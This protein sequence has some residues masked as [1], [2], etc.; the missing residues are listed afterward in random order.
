MKL[1][2]KTFYTP[3]KYYK[4]TLSH[5]LENIKYNEMKKYNMLLL[6]VF[7]GL[8]GCHDYFDEIKPTNKISAEALFASEEGVKAYMANLYFQTPIED[9]NWHAWGT[10]P[11]GGSTFNFRANNAGSFPIIMTDEAVN[12]EYDNISHDPWHYFWWDTGYRINKDLNM[13]FDAIPTLDLDQDEKNKLYGEACFLRAYTYFELVKLYGGVPII[14]KV[15]DPNDESTLFIPRSTEKETWDFVLATLDTAIV[16]LGDDNSD[17]RRAN[18]WGALALKSRV[19][20]HAAS[21]AKYWNDA[22]LSGEAVDKKL[23]GGMSQA[24]AQ[25][26]YEK[27]INASEE[28]IELGGYSLYNPNPSNP[29]E[30]AENYRQMFRNPNVAP[31]EV[32][33]ARGYTLQ[34]HGHAFQLWSETNQT[35]ESWPFGGRFNPIIELVDAYETYSN[36]GQSTPVIT[37]ADGNYNNY[38][39]Y[40][41]SR[42]Y[43][44]FDNPLEIF[45]DKDAR[46]RASIILPMSN[47]KGQQII[48]QGGIIKTNGAS[49]IEGAGQETIDGKT[50]YSFGAASENLFSGFLHAATHT[51]S[52]FLVKKFLDED[53]HPKAIWASCTN[54]W[55]E[56]RYAEILLNYMEAV[57]ESGQGDAGKAEQYLNA[58]RHRAGHTTD[59]PLTLEN[60]LRERRVE[61]VFENKRYWDLIRRREH[62]TEFNN[63]DRHALVPIFDIRSMKYIF[64]RQKITGTYTWSFPEHNYYKP[65]GG[66]TVNKLIQNPQY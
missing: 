63:R 6:I 34:E 42:D 9:F 55:I 59:I 45:A 64:V 27:C 57:A 26:Y 11:W 47:W 13:L 30:A 17:K 61:L 38:D 33:F 29:D 3:K 10:Q 19:A 16:N 23:V 36:P 50:Y 49:V 52:G 58:I 53:F 51:R 24:N 54:D 62:H 21:V 46:L 66:N 37:T 43:L 44:K 20:L 56:F 22:P 41:A 1:A 32:I 18:K 8:F 39:G 60:V 7:I 31:E 14:T 2:S 5:I 40:N 12:S 48:I 65:I 4:R 28:L 35:K 25:E 15:G